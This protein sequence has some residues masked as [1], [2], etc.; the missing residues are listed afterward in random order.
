MIQYEAI[1]RRSVLL[2]LFFLCTCTVFAQHKHFLRDEM[3]RHVVGRGFVVTT[4]ASGGEVFLNRDDYRRMVRLGANYQVIR[5]EL[6]KLSS[7]WGTLDPDYLLKLDSLVEMGKHEGIHS[8][9]KM[10]GYVRGFSWEEFWLNGNRQQETYTEAWKLI[11]ERYRDEPFVTGYDLLNEPRK[12]EM[13]ITYDDLTEDYLLPLYRKLIDEKDKYNPD[14]SGI[15]QSIFMNKGEGINGN[16]YAEIKAPIKRRNVVFAPHI[17]QARKDRVKPTLLRFEKEADLLK[18][19]VFIG[20]WGF[21]TFQSTDSSIAGTQGQ[22]EYM[23]FYIRTAELF[24]S[25]GYGTIKAWF[26]GNRTYQDFLPG[27]KSTWAIFSDD[28]HVGTVERKYI[29]DVIARPYPKAIAGDL[30]SFKYDFA[31]RTLD[32]HLTADNSKGASRIF[33]GADRHY[34]DGFSVVCNDDF[35]LCCNPLGN[36]GLEIC[37][38]GEHGNPAD[39]IWDS[40]RQQLVILAWPEDQKEMHLRIKPGIATF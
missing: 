13:D 31:M 27:G 4:N 5:L 22:L 15:I 40:S 38:A 7:S 30:H 16:Q 1:M 29:V 34:P 32:V 11:W 14:K 10:T 18:A 39:F 33:V 36:G 20:E 9:F 35:V 12:L 37:K 17:Y 2:Y 6:G 26:S 23:D 19:P 21:P 25:L 8:I 28:Q 24:D 3:G